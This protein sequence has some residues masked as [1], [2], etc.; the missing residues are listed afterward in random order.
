MDFLLYDGGKG[1]RYAFAIYDKDFIGT[2][3]LEKFIRELL[4]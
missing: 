3:G 4:S 1:R 2:Y